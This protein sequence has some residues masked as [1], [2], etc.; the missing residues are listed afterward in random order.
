MTDFQAIADRVEIE[1]LRGEF[2]DAAMMRDRARLASL[3]TE[4]G[5]LRMPDGSIEMTGREEIRTGGERLQAQWDFFVQNTHPGV[6]R[7]DGD[8]AT[9]RAYMQEIARLQNGFQG[10]NYAIYHDRYRRTDE[11][12]KFS[13]RVYEIRYLDTTTLTGSAPAGDPHTTQEAR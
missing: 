9:G 5:V 4:D 8:T 6:I 12:W 7:I 2:T 13:E 1:A 3:F 10:L 11:G